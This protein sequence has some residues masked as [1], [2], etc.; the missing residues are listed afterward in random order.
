MYYI[1]KS[2][3]PFVDIC[4]GLF[5]HLLGNLVK[6][7]TGNEILL[8]VICSI[9]WIFII[10]GIMK[11]KDKIR[12][13]FH[14]FYKQLFYFYLFTLLIMVIRGYLI[15]Y[16]YQWISIQGII[17]YHLY[18][19][20]YILPYFMP[21][22]VFIP[23]K[24]INFNV[25][26]KLSIPISIITIFLFVINSN[27]IISTSLKL[28]AGITQVNNQGIGTSI[29]SAYIP[30]SFTVLC[31]KYIDKKIWLLNCCA[32]ITAMMIYLITARRGNSFM[33]SLLLFF[34]FFFYIKSLKSYTKI[35]SITIIIILLCFSIY[36]LLN[37]NIFSFISERGLEDNRS[38]VDN[39]LLSQMTNWELFFGKGLNGRYYYPMALD[40]FFKGWRYGSETGFYNLVLKGGY[41]LAILHIIILLFPAILG[42]FK[43]NNILCK[44]CGFYI[45]LS[46]IEL[47][48]FGWLVFN[49][50]FLTIWIGFTLCYL[51]KIRQLNDCAIKRIFFRKK[52]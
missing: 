9:G 22:I 46:L 7:Q 5:I 25:L 33:T 42:I 48:P 40:D 2:N 1:T 4:L 11:I 28:A 15:D 14:N 16:P 47:Y 32:L 23:L 31:A 20:L 51:P 52:I 3:T 35:L 27:E 50:K 17:N 43:S 29:A 26:V 24:Y 6:G 49:L 18:S 37:T 8:A 45:I 36:Y 13:P 21:L 44:A 39:A 30:L 38:H 12:N 34:N 19:N 10:K 41:L